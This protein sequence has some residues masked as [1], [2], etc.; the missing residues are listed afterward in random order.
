M[1]IKELFREDA[2]GTKLVKF[3]SDAGFKI[4]NSVTNIAYG[5]AIELD[6][7]PGVYTETDEKIETEEEIIEEKPEKEEDS[8]SEDDFF[9]MLEKE[10][11]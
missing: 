7:F 1:V 10:L 5:E 4:L 6:T 9:S 11:L 2:D 3:Y 8:I